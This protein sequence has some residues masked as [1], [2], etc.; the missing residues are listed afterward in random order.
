MR[1]VFQAFALAVVMLAGCVGTATSSDTT[2]PKEKAAKTALE[3][4][5]LTATV[6]ESAF[7]AYDSEHELA[8]AK[9]ATSREDAETKLNAYHLKRAKVDRA[10]ADY[11]KAVAVA[12]QLK[13]DN[14]IATVGAAALKVERAVAELKDEP[15]SEPKKNEGGPR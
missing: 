15:K 3:A 1:G 4:A 14:S 5:L 11:F 12:L 10:F 13:D 9:T 2:T 7:H 6:A 8:I